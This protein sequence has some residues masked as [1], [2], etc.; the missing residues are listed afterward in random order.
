MQ[1]I[2]G[3]LGG[4]FV[5]GIGGKH[6][7]QI[8]INYD[9]KIFSVAQAFFTEVAFTFFLV[10][11][12]LDTAT[13]SIKK[14]NFYGLAI[15]SCLGTAVCAVGINGISVACLNF[16]VFFGTTVS[17]LAAGTEWSDLSWDHLWIYLAAPLLGAS[18]AALLF[19]YLYQDYDLESATAYAGEKMKHQLRRYLNENGYW[20]AASWLQLQSN[21][22]FAIWRF[23]N[24]NLNSSLYV[25]RERKK[26]L[27][28]IKYKSALLEKNL[29][30]KLFIILQIQ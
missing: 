15:G 13:S 3:T 27:L 14:N 23:M 26:N 5:Y 25:K 2:G 11:T 19:K 16:A 8:C 29:L 1:I 30:I 6:V 28:F 24:I 9:D 10:N 4:L 20:G 12:V 7:G 21:K 22:H 17:S 18:L